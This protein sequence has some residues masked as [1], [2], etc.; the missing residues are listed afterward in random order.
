MF[1]EF[2]FNILK[3]EKFEIFYVYKIKK[4]PVQRTLKFRFMPKR[5]QLV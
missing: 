3:N 4:I 5:L 1:L 2:F